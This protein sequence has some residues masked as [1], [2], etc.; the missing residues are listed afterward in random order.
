MA[1]AAPVATQRFNGFPEGGIDFFLQL[2]A[3]QSRAWFKAHQDE[4][5]RLWK[6]PLELFVAEL[7][8]RLAKTY[9][10]LDDVTPHFF[11]IQRDTRFAKDKSPYKTYVAADLPIRPAP[12]DPEQ[13]GH[14]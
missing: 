1:R 2:E 14:G 10:G 7:Q 11:R 13:Y 12:H 5:E 8:E 4:F 9:P 6:H 3:E